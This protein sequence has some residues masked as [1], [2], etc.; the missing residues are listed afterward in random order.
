MKKL[1]YVLY[2]IVAGLFTPVLCPVA[3]AQQKQDA[4][5]VTGTAV[6][7]HGSPVVGATVVVTGTQSGATT[8]TRGRFTV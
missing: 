5:Q 6:D 4:P 8:D 2:F 7:D 3:A 1:I